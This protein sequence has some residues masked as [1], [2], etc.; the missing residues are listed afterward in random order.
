MERDYKMENK[1]IQWANKTKSWLFEKINNI[2]KPLAKLSE[3]RKE[4]IPNDK[5][6]DAKGNIQQKK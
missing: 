1:T 3:S 2:N 4:M 6:R 5:I